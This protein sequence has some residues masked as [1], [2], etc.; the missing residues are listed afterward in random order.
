MLKEEWRMHSEIFHGSSF[1]TFPLVIFLISLTGSY[2][3]I[4][5]STLG[6][7]ALANI[8]GF[9]GVFMGLSVGAI[10]F[11]SK[12]AMENVLGPYNLLIYSS[13]TLPVSK[14][15][16]LGSFFVMDTIYYTAFFLL[17]LSAGVLLVSGLAA[18]TGI[19]M[20]FGGFVAGLLLSLVVSSLSAQIPNYR[21]SYGDR[22]DPLTEKTI[23]DVMRSTGGIMKVVFSLTIL[24][25]FYWALVIYFPF[26]SRFLQN[27]VISFGVLIG[28][29][30]LTVY[31]WINRFDQA[32]EYLYLPVNA[33]ML[34]NS[35]QK[36]F[37]IVSFPLTLMFLAGVFL[38]YPVSII[39]AVLA[40][41]ASISTQIYTVGL[42]SFLTGLRPN[43]RLFDSK[44][45][46]KYLIGNS[47][48]VLPLLMISLFIDNGL[49]SYFVA[50]L[51]ITAGS[52]IFLANK[53]KNSVET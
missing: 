48:F 14:A 51:V 4:E 12:D 39:E 53:A 38:I 40:V 46:V 1:A 24:T 8:I 13:R 15:K 42:G 25:G 10:G 7:N 33:E 43:Y 30:S 35:K 29:V 19:G 22:T 28:T 9:L 20:L 34:L 44:V 6:L 3:L 31:N 26:A 52:G 49:Y 17:P 23:I 27:P 18:L 2:A 37:I 50:L 32:E 45:F 36:A 21:T 41:A 11:W 47:I 16:L 5:L